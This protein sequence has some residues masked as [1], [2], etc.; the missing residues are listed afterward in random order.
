MALVIGI[1]DHGELMV[2]RDGQTEALLQADQIRV[3]R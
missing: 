1:G 2:E 3:I